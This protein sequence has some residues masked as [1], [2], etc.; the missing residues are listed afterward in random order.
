MRRPIIAANWKMNCT[1]GQAN[2]LVN[3]FKALVTQVTEVDIVLAPPFTALATV[4]QL[5]S[6]SNIALAAQ[7]M[8]W[9]ESGAYTG[10]VSPGML[11]DI[12]CKYVII[13]HSERR[14]YFGETDETV[15]KKIKKALEHN[16]TPIVCV[17]ESLAQRE[18]NETQAV[19][20]LQIRRGLQGLTSEQ[21]QKIVLAYEPIWAIGTGKTATPE[22]ANDVHHFIRRKLAGIFDEATASAVRIQYGGSVKPASVDELM[23]QSDID[24]ALVGGAALKADSFA[25]IVKFEA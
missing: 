9:E 7:N 8:Y 13:G 12:G 16:L 15:N 23:A 21:M 17:G 5:I 6:G 10:E 14:A 4:G 2:E 22:Q 20:V 11:I 19:V 24:G 3:N 18:N 1:T 25:R